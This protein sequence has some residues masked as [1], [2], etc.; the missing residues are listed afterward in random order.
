MNVTECDGC[1][2]ENEL[3]V[4]SCVYC[5]NSL[6]DE[7]SIEKES[8]ELEEL[9]QQCSSWIGKYEGIVSNIGALNNAKQI[10]S[11]SSTPIFGA[12]ISSSFGSKAMS[13]SEILSKVHHYLDLL[14]IKSTNSSI[15]REKVAQFK[16]RYERA[17]LKEK[18]TNKKK[19]LLIVGL[20]LA[21]VLFIAFCL[22]M[23]NI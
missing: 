8:D 12:I 14:E 21:F 10:D 4:S 9:V 11:V 17:Q 7:D 16:K 2:A 19:V 3:L 15:L 22:I 13:Y 23:A 20:V 18:E 5:G 6:V 1:G